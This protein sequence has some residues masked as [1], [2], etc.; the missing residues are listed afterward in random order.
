MRLNLVEGL[1]RGRKVGSSNRLAPT[2]CRLWSMADPLILSPERCQST[3]FPFFQEPSLSGAEPGRSAL[4]GKYLGKS[5][6]HR[7]DHAAIMGL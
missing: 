1:V 3:S 2:I 5:I 6:S 4:T 7:K